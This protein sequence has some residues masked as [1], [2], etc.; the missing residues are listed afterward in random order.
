MVEAA[1]NYPLMDVFWTMVIFFAWMIWIWLLITIF[2]DLFSRR[3]ISGWGK[4]G[5]TLLVLVL[6]FLG[7]LIYM[8]SQSTAMADRRLAQVQAQQES[9]DSYVKSV[10]A[11]SGGGAPAS[12]IGRA[13]ELLDTGAI[14]QDEY[15]AIK[16]KALAG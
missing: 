6:P 5:W 14:T 11:T 8:I 2:A 15:D 12:E 1:S 7:V 3:D 10:A 16:A 13:K 9:F 4:A